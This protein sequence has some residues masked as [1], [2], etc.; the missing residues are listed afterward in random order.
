MASIPLQLPWPGALRRACRSGAIARHPWWRRLWQAADP[1][2]HQFTLAAHAGPDGGHGRAWTVVL[3]GNLTHDG[4]V[5]RSHGLCMTL[6]QRGARELIIDLSGAQRAD[7]KLIAALVAIQRASN[8][9][10]VP[11]RVIQSPH[12]RQ[13]IELCGVESVCPD[14]ASPEIKALSPTQSRF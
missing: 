7:T 4:A 1:R 12:V 11:V 13:W 14:E 10:A 6:L 2:S 9:A 8:A 3:A 5:T